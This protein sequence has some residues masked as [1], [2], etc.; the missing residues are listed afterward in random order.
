MNKYKQHGTNRRTKMRFIDECRLKLNIEKIA[1]Y[2][3]DNNIRN[4]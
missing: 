2:D 3:L 1:K 4:R